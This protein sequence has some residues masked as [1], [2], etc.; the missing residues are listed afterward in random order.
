MRARKVCE[1]AT[2]NRFASLYLPSLL[3]TNVENML[4]HTLPSTCATQ[5]SM[6]P[7]LRFFH[8]PRLQ[9]RVGGGCFDAACTFS[10]SLACKASRGLEFNAVRTSSAPLARETECVGFY[11]ILTLFAPPPP[12]LHA[13]AS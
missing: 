10:P 6:T 7:L 11:C 8:L 1:E 2:H 12:S 9:E 4:G 5:R 13:T 3:P